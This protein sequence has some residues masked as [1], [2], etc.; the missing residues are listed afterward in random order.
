MSLQARCSHAFSPAVRARGQAY[1]RHGQVSAVKVTGNRATAVAHGSQVYR[2][3]MSVDR[4]AGEVRLSCSCP[5]AEGDLC[6]HLWALLLVLDHKFPR[7]LEPPGSDRLDVSLDGAGSTEGDDDELEDDEID[8]DEEW[9]AWAAAS[10][11]KVRRTVPSRTAASRARERAPTV[12]RRAPTWR[13]RLRSVDALVGGPA[14]A[15][16]S[17]AEL[18]LRLD[19]EA[20]RQRGGLVVR[21][22]LRRP[23]ADGCLGGAQAARLS[24]ASAGQLRR[25][26]DRR[27]IALL[28][29]CARA[30]EPAH[31]AGYAFS[32]HSE[33]SSAVLVGGTFAALLPPLCAS[34]R[35]GLAGEDGALVPLAWDGDRPFR[36]ALEIERGG[37]AGSLRARGVLRRDGELI[38]LEQARL[39]H[40][41]GAVVLDGRIILVDDQRAA[42]ALVVGLR[43]DGSMEAGGREAGAMLEAL[44]AA[45]G[46]DALSLASDVDMVCER[47]RPVPR[48][49]FE[50]PDR[51]SGHVPACI[52]FAY[53]HRRVAAC[54]GNGDPGAGVEPALA[55]A[56]WMSGDR[57]ALVL[58]D[59]NGEAEALA[60]IAEAGVA[61]PRPGV[62]TAS[63][64]LP[65]GEVE[66]GR[67]P[68]VVGRLLESGLD[69]LARGA[70]I[71]R[72]G[73]ASL[74]VSSGIDWFELA[75]N[76]DF[77]GARAELP[78]LLRALRDGEGLVPLGDGT[79]GLIPEAWLARFGIYARLG[80]EQGDAL[81]FP[82]AQAALLDALLEHEPEAQIDATFARLRRRLRAH[83]EVQPR[84]APRGFRGELR[85]YQMTGLGWLRFLE[86]LG[87]G[88]CL[89]D[90][91]GLG[92]T[93]Q[94][95][96]HLAGRRERRRKAG[97]ADRPSLIV[98]P[99][100]LLFNWQAEAARFT[101]GLGVLVHHGTA[102]CDR[103]QGLGTADIILTTYGT[104]VRDVDLFQKVELDYAVLDEAQAMKNPR[105]QA[106]RSCRLLRSRHR[107]ALTGTPV[108]NRLA[109]LG[110]IFEFLNPGMID[111]SS[112]LA[113]LVAADA[114]E[115]GLALLARALRPFLLRRTKE[116]VL[117]ELPPKVEHTVA[118]E[119]DGKQR[120]LYRE[121]RDHYRIALLARVEKQGL[122]RSKIH[123]L[124]ALL[125]L[126]QAACHPGLID[127]ERKGEPSAK[128][129]ALIERI[130][131]VVAG[132]HKA[133]VFS[134]FTSFLA[135]ARHRLERAEISYEYL[136]GK[137]RD[138]AARVARFQSDSDCR[139]FL[140]SLKAAGHGLNLTA[141]DY[142]FLLDPW[143]NPAVE[144]QAVDRAHRLGQ[145]RRVFTYRLI[146]R[147]T[148]EE[149]VL[150]LQA[151][152]RRLAEA[153]VQR[154]P[155]LL[156]QL[157]T[158]DLEF[159]LQ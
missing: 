27:L 9:P 150:A 25:S 128:L 2:L 1:A 45:V 100:T 159:L 17:P 111:T 42:R 72:G 98:V 68:A 129:D 105:S 140:L 39:A 99:K 87:L 14:H 91:M 30:A 132:G 155:G 44:A 138:R 66:A 69:V 125:R 102:R 83:T 119:L 23:R 46:P 142:V 96:A 76:L 146:A 54:R 137:T 29:A 38:P 127:R 35:F 144:A 3:E 20:S 22:Y 12:T 97:D 89:A 19:L 157:S 123:V 84:R 15:E 92:K 40:V 36:L 67:F 109:D 117:P 88:G 101:P 145:E 24:R 60:R 121:L 33:A 78:A 28:L 116:Q 34:G 136:D 58:R 47:G 77:D 59:P 10:P 141:A 122:A 74:R 52:D 79:F 104:L 151:D 51:R 149:K 71:R 37:R 8:D 135:L 18:E 50:E 113:P 108:E 64:A 48:V 152:K 7:R 115:E 13:E 41:G 126:R 130:V 90:D 61:P 112:V 63:G 124:E 133:L 86:E 53:G 26:E 73:R 11:R 70:R 106:A 43:A 139:V 148:V 21:F 80:A 93:I 120:R 6:K 156:G 107:L 5:Y 55:P 4:D 82:R 103:P 118:C 153:I 143:W 57:R 56:A 158:R 62:R 49:S 32:D 95:L 85:A 147:D 75:A 16:G 65:D 134:Q 31:M 154:D 94:V 81:R 110:S 114:G 131:E